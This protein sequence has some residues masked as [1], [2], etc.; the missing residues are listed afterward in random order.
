M[1]GVDQAALRAVEQVSGMPVSISTEP[2]SSTGPIGRPT[3]PPPVSN[4]PTAKSGTFCLSGQPTEQRDLPA[5]TASTGSTSTHPT[6]NQP[7][8]A[9]PAL[10]TNSSMPPTAYRPAPAAP[11]SRTFALAWQP[12]AKSRP[13]GRH[14][15]LPPR[16]VDTPAYT[17]RPHLQYS[18]RGHTGLSLGS[19]LVPVETPAY[20]C[21][22]YTHHEPLAVRAPPQLEPPPLN[23]PATAAAVS[24]ATPP[25]YR[26]VPPGS[27][28]PYPKPVTPMVLPSASNTSADE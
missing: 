14:R 21:G 11:S 8:S 7:S 15:L 27:P 3:A 16:P 4:Y 2:G 9:Y 12:T 28:V 18:A 1:A 25:A 17:Y 20:R 19:D 26:P 5:S 6:A 24:S 13:T 22:T 23:R 10:Y